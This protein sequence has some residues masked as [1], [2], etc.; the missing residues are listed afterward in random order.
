NERVN[1]VSDKLKEGQV[2]RVKVIEMDDKGRVRLS[3]KALLAEA[4]A[5][6]EPP[7]AAQ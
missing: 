6:E 3:M 1:A 5:T 2:V 7:P 4:E